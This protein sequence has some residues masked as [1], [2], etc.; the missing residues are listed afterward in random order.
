VVLGVPEPAGA[1]FLRRLV[2]LLVR[3]AVPVRAPGQLAGHLHLP[4]RGGGVHEHD[5][6]VEA[7]QVR[8]RGEDLR[9][10]LLQRG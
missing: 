9:G 5:A 2:L 7:E 4:V 10:D 8:H 1:F 3:A 6:D